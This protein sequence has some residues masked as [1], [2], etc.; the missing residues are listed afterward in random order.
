[1]IRRRPHSVRA[2]DG[3]DVLVIGGYTPEMDGSAAGL[4]VQAPDQTRRSATTVSVAESPSP[5][6]VVAHPSRPWLFTAGEGSP[7]TVGSYRIEES[8]ELA[9]L[10]R[11]RDRWRLSPATW[12]SRRMPVCCWSRTTGRGR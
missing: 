9:E 2:F 7:A 4:V 8:G 3:I 5:S 10:S 1:M 12:R 11:L 6:Y